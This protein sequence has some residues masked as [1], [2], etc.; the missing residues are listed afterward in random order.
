MPK[1][2]KEKIKIG[3]S[4]C[5]FGALTRYNR[6]GWDK[7]ES[8]G[9]EKDA[10]IWTPVCP[11]VMSGLGVPRLP[12][13]LVDG[14]GD[15]FWQ[16]KARMKNRKGENVST[17]VRKG[18]QMAMD[19]LKNAQIEAFVFMEGSPSCG[20]YRTTLKNKRLGKPP[21]VFGS[22]LLEEDIFL[23]PALDLDSPVKWW[24]WRRR[25]HMFVWL[26]RE[27]LNSK[28]QIID[29]WHDFKFVCQEIDRAKADEIGRTIATMPKKYSIK[30]AND[31]KSSILKLLRRPSSIKRIKANA[32][33]QMAHYNKHMG[34]KFETKMPS[35]ESAKRKFFE[36]LISLEKEAINNK[37]NIGIV[38]VLYREDSR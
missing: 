27:E 24:D 28:K 34:L 29:M 33:K 9:R 7:L 11:E 35:T 37:I 8:L 38:P 17:Q 19:N 2:I 12:M 36:K 3:I 22:L 15:D 13:K 1:I 18:A 20:V 30:F 23:I 25:L 4:A 21:G 32:E 6:K 31:I 26:K 5:N 10:F 14:N 16:T